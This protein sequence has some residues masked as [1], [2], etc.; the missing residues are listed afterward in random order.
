[1]MDHTLPYV[2]EGDV[3]LV[4]PEY[5]HFFGV[6]GFGDRELLLTVLDAT[7]GE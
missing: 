7:P 6:N 1:M 4:I 3:V 5:S 2:R